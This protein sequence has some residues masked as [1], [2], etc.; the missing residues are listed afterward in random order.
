MMFY[1]LTI[2]FELYLRK[3]NLGQ[4]IIFKQKRRDANAHHAFFISKN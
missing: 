4:D 2:I 1:A 3:V